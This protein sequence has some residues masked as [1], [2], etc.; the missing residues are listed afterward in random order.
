MHTES[1]YENFPDPGNALDRVASAV[2][3]SRPGVGEKFTPTEKGKA[4]D[5][6]AFAVG[7]SRPTFGQISRFQSPSDP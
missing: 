6:V 1:G 4:L 2:G 7:M 5:R 3:M